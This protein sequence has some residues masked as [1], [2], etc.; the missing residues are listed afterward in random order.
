MKCPNCKY[1]IKEDK[2]LPF[3]AIILC[4]ILALITLYGLVK[5]G[6]L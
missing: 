2:E 4:A 6:L 3:W 1:V 5:G